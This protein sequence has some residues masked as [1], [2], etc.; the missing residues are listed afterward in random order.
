M[1]EIIFSPTVLQQLGE[2][3]ERTNNKNETKKIK[4]N[5][6][7]RPYREKSSIEKILH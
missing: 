6:F 1:V 4:I 3:K 7:I 5:N 2:K